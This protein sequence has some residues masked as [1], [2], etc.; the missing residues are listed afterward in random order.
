MRGLNSFL[1][2]VVIRK[3]LARNRRKNASQN[4]LG[5]GLT[6]PNKAFQVAHKALM[7]FMGHLIADVDPNEEE[8]IECM[9]QSKVLS[10]L[11][12]RVKVRPGKE[13]SG[14]CIKTPR[15]M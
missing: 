8:K 2:R 6:S 5:F 7:R 12:S 1:I 3:V 13:T 9:N 11:G 14:I 4:F 15:G 10:G